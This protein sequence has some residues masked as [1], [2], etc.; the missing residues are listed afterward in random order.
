MSVLFEDYQSNCTCVV[1]NCRMVS[2][3]GLKQCE[4]K[5]P[6]STSKGA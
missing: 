5:W 2:N 1:S 6:W 3:N 4:G